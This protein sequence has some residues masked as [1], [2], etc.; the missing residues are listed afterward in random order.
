M[1]VNLKNIRSVMVTMVMVAITLRVVLWAML[2]L[3]P[4]LIS[5]IVFLSAIITIFGIMWKRSS[6]L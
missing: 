6:K 2:P 3:V 4:Y 5:G 1:K